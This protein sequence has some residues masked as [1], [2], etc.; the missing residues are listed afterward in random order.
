MWMNDVNVAQD[1]RVECFLSD[2]KKTSCIL[3]F[4]VRKFLFAGV[5]FFPI[6][7]HFAKAVNKFH[8]LVFAVGTSSSCMTAQTDGFP[9]SLDFWYFSTEILSPCLHLFI[10]SQMIQRN[11]SISLRLNHSLCNL[12]FYVSALG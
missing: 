6:L 12:R 2:L 10:H 7:C 11:K 8:W 5:F 3:T 4:K 9:K 1:F